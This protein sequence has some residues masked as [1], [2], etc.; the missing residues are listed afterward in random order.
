MAGRQSGPSR[1]HTPPQPIG[2]TDAADFGDRAPILPSE[3]CQLRLTAVAE[4]NTTTAITPN[5]INMA[6]LKGKPHKTGLLQCTNRVVMK[7]LPF[8]SKFKQHGARF[9][10]SRIRTPGPEG[11]LNSNCKKICDGFDCADGDTPWSAMRA[12]R[13]V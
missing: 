9:L 11:H 10:S 13:S 12:N 5:A 8:G 3:A 1:W 2:D 4:M 7:E 6:H